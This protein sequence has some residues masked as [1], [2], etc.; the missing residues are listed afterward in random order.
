LVRAGGI[1]GSLKPKQFVLLKQSI[2]FIFCVADCNEKSDK[3]SKSSKHL[4]KHVVLKSIRTLERKASE[5]TSRIYPMENSG[6]LSKG[7][8]KMKVW[9]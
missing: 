1:K 7:F 9:R 8:G 2:S 4:S 6:T 3:G 5:I